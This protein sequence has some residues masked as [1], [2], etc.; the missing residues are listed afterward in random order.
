MKKIIDFQEFVLE[1]KSLERTGWKERDIKNPESVADHTFSVA[2]LVMQMSDKMKLDTEKCMRM[3]LLHEI[4]EA[5][6]GDITPQNPKYKNKVKFEKE[7]I[8]KIIKETG[9]DFFVPVLEEYEK[10][11]SKEANLVHDMD[12]IEMLIQAL[13]YEKKHPDK[14]LQEFF[15]YV[16]GKL[17]LE[18]S[19]SLFLQII[20]KRK[21]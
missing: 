1:L 3:A 21:S 15:D 4:A 19:K 8:K 10:N 5:K 18:E 14:N 20:K 16:N 12:K 2:V 11:L 7:A 13:D 6:I 9:N 17:K